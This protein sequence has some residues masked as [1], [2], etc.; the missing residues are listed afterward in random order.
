[1]ITG[2]ARLAG[3]AGWP[4]AHSRSPRLHNHWIARHGLDAAYVPLPIP[5]ERFAECVRAL[6]ACGFR[7]MNVTIPHKEAAFAVCDTVSARARRAGAVNTLV[8]DEG[9]AITGDCTDGVGFLAS[10]GGFDPR[11]GPAV[12]MGAGGAARA[13]AAALLDAGCPRVTLVNRSR[14]RAEAL[15][16][17]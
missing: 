3:V 17:A 9:G 10:L 13:I 16:E 2:R 4:V 7:G 14:A 5:P 15:A 12:L 8:F 6:A 1:M 11:S